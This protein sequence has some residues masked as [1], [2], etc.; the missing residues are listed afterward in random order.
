M[1]VMKNE[2]LNNNQT[3]EH[4]IENFQRFFG[5][6]IKALN[7]DIN[8]PPTY[9]LLCVEEYECTIKALQK[10]KDGPEP[11]AIPLTDDRCLYFSLARQVITP[12]ESH[13]I[14]VLSVQI[15]PDL[16]Y[17]PVLLKDPNSP[18]KEFINITAPPV[19][20]SDSRQ[21]WKLWQFFSTFNPARDINWQR[22]TQPNIHQRKIIEAMGFSD[23]L[24]NVEPL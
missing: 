3:H 13:N 5:P 23:R 2:E 24:P 7:T 6:L 14:L 1:S 20:D 8:L 4:V 21:L 22:L 16:T 15:E 9:Q 11:V 17:P 18:P 12:D 19:D 10:I